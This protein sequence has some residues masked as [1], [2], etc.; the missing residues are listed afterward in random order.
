MM[1]IISIIISFTFLVG[2]VAV[3]AKLNPLTKMKVPHNAIRVIVLAYML[4]LIL[5]LP[6]VYVLKTDDFN[7]QFKQSDA[8]QNQI[9]LIQ[10]NFYDSINSGNITNIEKYKVNSFRFTDIV[11]ELRFDVATSSGLIPTWVQK[12]PIN[13]GIIEVSTYK[14]PY[15]VGGLDITSQLPPLEI[16]IYKGVLKVESKR[17]DLN[18]YRFNT[19]F[20]TTQFHK[21]STEFNNQSY[22]GVQGVYVSIPKDMVVDI[23]KANVSF[24]G[25][26][27]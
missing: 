4:V 9:A 7:K 19:N 15:V 8:D 10:S 25:E 27:K 20:P 18:T 3:V 1:A 17:I 6:L 12:K 11:D 24:I 26:N 16:F 23:E 5:S 22:Y 14:T 21:N 13:D 2:V